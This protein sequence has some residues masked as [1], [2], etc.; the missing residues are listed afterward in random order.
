MKKITLIF[1][2]FII[3]YCLLPTVYC[4]SGG[5]QVNLQG[6]KQTGMGHTGTGL[7]LGASSSFFNPGAFSFVNRNHI[8][9]G[10]SFIFPRTVY[11][12]PY[13]GNYTTET[14]HAVGTP[15]T[16]Y[17]SFRTKPEKKWNAGLAV[18]T[19]FG[20]GIKYEDDWK[21]QFILRE[22]SLKT[23][24][25]QPTFGYQVNDRLGIGIGY[26]YGFGNLLLRK[27]I[28]TQDMNGNYG[29][30]K[31]TGKA[32]G[33]GF[34][35]GIFYKAT[36]RLTIGLSYRSSVK[37]KLKN[38]KANFTVPLFLKDS[39]PSTTFSTSIKLPQGFNFGI[40][41]KL[42]EKTT[43]A[44]DIN[45]VGWSS[46][47][48][49]SFDFKENTSKLEDINSP[50]K[51]KDAFIFRLGGEHQLNEN[52]IV[53]AGIYYD[54]TP[55]QD[56]YITP[57]TPDSDKLG[58]TAGASYKIADKFNIDISLLF[59]EG[60]KRTDTNLE[61]GFGGTWKSRAVIPGIGLEYIF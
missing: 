11:L 41:Y 60:R 19:P 36:D 31:L 2:S 56:G 26:V 6:Q 52:I 28:R 47:D 59:L 58:I 46:Y 23:I 17:S 3:A 24:Y 12:E 25:I 8:A 35:A 53:R 5:F 1:I 55:V 14:V 10:G 32:S 51:Y 49:L 43:L 57:E 4:F 37:V 45:Y 42:T 61:T 7:V 18:Y 33:H 54:P 34:N 50:R 30:G 16:F 44:F 29:E 22:M 15:F 27:A 13:P 48:T 20:S 38:G 21:G 9:V 40:G 39:I